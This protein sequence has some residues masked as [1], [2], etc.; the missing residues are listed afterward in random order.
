MKNKTSQG[1]WVTN[2]ILLEKIRQK[3]VIFPN[4]NYKYIVIR[5]RYITICNVTSV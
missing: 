5:I 4:I 1:G 3:Y 2:Y